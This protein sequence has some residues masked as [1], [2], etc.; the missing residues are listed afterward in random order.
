M[1]TT[2]FNITQDKLNSVNDWILHDGCPIP[3]EI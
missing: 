3:D 1:Q 2:K